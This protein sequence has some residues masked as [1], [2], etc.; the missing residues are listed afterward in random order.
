MK[1]IDVILL[2]WQNLVGNKMRSFLTIAGVG[3]GIGAIIF[4]VGIGFGLQQLTINKLVSS[5]TVTALEVFSDNPDVLKIDDKVISRIKNLPQVEKVSAINNFPGQIT[6]SSVTS[7]SLIRVVD[8]NYYSLAPGE[9]L[10]GVYPKNA[11]EAIVSFATAKTFGLENPVD[12]VGQAVKISVFTSITSL[13]SAEENKEVDLKVVGVFNDASQLIEIADD[14]HTAV[15]ADSY[16]RLKIKAKTSDDV[17]SL[18]AQITLLGFNST[19]LVS[20]IKEINQVFRWFEFILAGFG[21]IALIVASIGMFNT[22]TVTLLERTRDI[23]I[24]RAIGTKRRD[25]R[26]LF[27]LEAGMIGLAGGIMGIIFAWIGVLFVNGGVNMLAQSARQPK[28]T[29]YYLPVQ[30]MLLILGFS[31][32]IGLLTGVYP[33]LRASRLNPLVA[34]KYE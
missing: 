24:M 23:G 9:L 28:V 13:A 20:K 12:F 1:I 32:L 14:E 17:E 26:R 22:M 5:A 21:L 30:F 19:S 34:L 18:Q 33:A 2:S 16:S 6:V 10:A 29:I 31:L 4:L 7:E 11:G 27:I 3:V 8:K 25:V 15:S